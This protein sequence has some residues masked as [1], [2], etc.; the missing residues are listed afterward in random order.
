ME[1]KPRYSRVSDILDLAI[2]M[3]SKVLGVTINEIAERYN[4]SRRTAE[5]MRDSLTNI[6]PQVDEI[7]T[8][9][10]QKHWGF[11]NFSM[12]NLITFTP[13]EL[14]NIEQLQRRTTNKE[15]KEELGKTV[16]KIKAL[17]RKNLGS[18]ENNIELFM[19][20]EGYAVR[21]MPQ[22]KISM[23]IIDIMR[24]AMQHSKMVQGIYHDKQ[25]LLEP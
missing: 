23:E 10:T 1:D 6:F 19:Q 3:Q 2:F 7:E 5:R 11:T 17:A 20:T 21:Q 4:V 12:S 15:M 13:K 16:E 14:A 9:D 25:R 22:Y 18:V 8:D 24:D